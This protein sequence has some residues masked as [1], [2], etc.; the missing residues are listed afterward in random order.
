MRVLICSNDAFGLGHLRRSVKLAWAIHAEYPSLPVLLVSGSHMLHAF[1]LP[2]NTD[3]LKLPGVLMDGIGSYTARHLSVPFEELSRL[4]RNVLLETALAYQPDLVIVDRRPVGVKGEMLSA[5]RALKKREKRTTLVLSLRDIVGADVTRGEWHAD[6]SMRVLD[7][8]Y[9]EIWVFGTQVLYDPVKEYQLPPAIA[10]KVRFCGYL[11]I[12]PP[13]APREETRRA[14]HI[15]GEVF[16]LVTV[17]D[18]RAG[19]PILDAYLGALEI[20]PAQPRTVSFLMAAPELHQGELRRLRERVN[21]LATTRP[22]HR[23]TLLDFFPRLEDYIAA[24]DLIVSMAGY[25][26][27]T[28]VMVLEKRAIVIPRL[29]VLTE[30]LLRASLF[31]RLGLVTMLHPDQLSPG[32]MAEALLRAL[33]AP[34]PSRRQMTGLGLHFGG[35]IQM[36]KHVARL[37]GRQCPSPTSTQ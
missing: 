26:T 27:L 13:A 21:R 36:R 19:F 34:P 37:L 4:R 7:E 16:I 25:N 33:G 32:S 22:E 14:L 24:A 8:L 11:G 9:D 5:L 15:T 3:C 31:E 35:Q 29:Q 10:R 2:P 28:E 1:P 20:F 17:G 6:D 23:V 30:Q 12:E 18:G